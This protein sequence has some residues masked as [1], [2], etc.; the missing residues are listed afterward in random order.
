[1]KSNVSFVS[2]SPCKTWPGKRLFASI[3]RSNG[4]SI[5]TAAP[6]SLRGPDCAG[7]GSCCTH[8]CSEGDA[9][10][11]AWDGTMDAAERRMTVLVALFLAAVFIAVVVDRL[12]A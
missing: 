2:A 1:M 9:C 11:L 12:F 7:A 10:P 4:L 8:A 3:L 6:E 5:S